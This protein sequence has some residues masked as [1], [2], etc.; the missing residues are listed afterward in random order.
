MDYEITLLIFIERK[1][2]MNQNNYSNSEKQSAKGRKS[3]L[4]IGIILLNISVFMAAF[5][6]SF[7]MIINP[8]GERDEQVQTLTEQNIKLES[9]AQLLQD[10]LEVVESE[11]DTYKKRYNSSSS[12]SGSSKNSSGSS[13]SSGSSNSSSSSSDYEDSDEDT[14]RSSRDGGEINMDND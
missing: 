10:Q 12:S 14:H 2:L 4:I 6:F 13:L 1:N 5:V 7:N 11:L 9:D 8:I 3:M